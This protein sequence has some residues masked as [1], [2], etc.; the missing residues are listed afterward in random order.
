MET[1]MGADYNY[2][3]FCSYPTMQPSDDQRVTIE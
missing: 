2:R 1:E 3:S